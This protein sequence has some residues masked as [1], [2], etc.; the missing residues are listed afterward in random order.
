MIFS[1]RMG[2]PEMDKFWT[3]LCSREESGKL[4]KSEL[5]VFKR[6]LK[7]LHLLSMNPR[8][9]GL[10]S[11]EIDSLSR[12]AG[13]K[14]WQSYVENN[15]PAAGRIFWAYAPRKCEITILGFEPHPED[16]KKSGYLKVKLSKLPPL[17]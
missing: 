12:I 13:F 2:L 17:D 7:A 3:D 11:H 6:L 15:T 9:P 8:H 1:I 14:V 16:K 4:D 5:K 10:A